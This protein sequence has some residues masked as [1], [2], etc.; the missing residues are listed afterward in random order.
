MG[1]RGRMKCRLWWPTH[2]SSTLQPHSHSF[3]V[4]FGWFISSSQS[5][6]SLDIVVAFALDESSLSSSVNLQEILHQTNGNMPLSLQDKCTFSFLGYCEADL[7]GNGQSKMTLSERGTHINS[8]ESG[9]NFRGSQSSN[10]LK[11]GSR[12]CG[13]H[14]VDT[15]LEHHRVVLAR[16]D[17]CFQLIC[18]FPE[19]KDRNLPFIPELH[20]LHWNR[21]TFSQLDLHV[22]YNL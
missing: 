15:L 6:S 3:T 16:S 1:K 7:S 8:T 13:C 10:V 14:K 19:N 2:L 12:S 18:S 17:N 4:F 20:H 11:K 5:S 22:C 9:M 21:E